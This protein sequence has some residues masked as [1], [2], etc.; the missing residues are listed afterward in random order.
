VGQ[1]YKITNNVN[2]KCY[3]GITKH[4]FEKRYYSGNWWKS[5]SVNRLLKKSVLK[6]GIENFTV[7][8]LEDG[9]C[10]TKLEERERVYITLFSSFVPSGYNLTTGGNY[11]YN[12]SIE[13]IEKT[14]ASRRERFLKYGSSQKGK[15]RNPE[16][17]RKMMETQKR[18]YTEG[19][20]Q[21]WNKGKKTGRPSEKSILD[22]AK[23]HLKKVACYDKNGNLVKVYEGL[24]HTKVDGFRPCQVCLVCKGKGKSHKG[25]T[26][27]YINDS[28]NQHNVDS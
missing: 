2:K 26:F 10:E 17:I 27:K 12:V 11:K 15:P 3:V 24:I 5:G 7:V 8:I 14:V 9:I 4:T 22:S 6:Y 13:S 18:Q 21:P 28:Q 20:R 19:T 23:A 25:Y 16:S 1:V